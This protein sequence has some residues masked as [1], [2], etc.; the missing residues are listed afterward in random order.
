[1]K[2]SVDILHKHSACSEGLKWYTANG[3]PDTVG[4][5]ISALLQSDNDNRHQWS[6]WL[7]SEMLPPNNKIRYA[8]YAAELVIELFEKQYPNDRRPRNAIDAA[9]A[10]LKKPS[11]AAR[12]AAWAAGDAARA[13][14]GAAWAAGDAARAT[15]DAARATWAAAWAAGAAAYEK[16]IKY[17][18]SLIK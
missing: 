18:L 12:D 7:L 14:A 11:G 8:I 16:I 17:G 2:L 3:S 6:S 13:A 10:Y 15:W 9:I 1:M 4:K 5:T